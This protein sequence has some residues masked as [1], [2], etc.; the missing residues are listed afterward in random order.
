MGVELG[1]NVATLCRVRDLQRAIAEFGGRFRQ[2]FGLTLDEG[3][4]LCSLERAGRMTAGELA[5]ALGLLPSKVSKVIASVE[6]RGLVERS[7]GEPDHRQMLVSL[8]GEGRVLIGRVKA[9]PP[10]LPPLLE[11]AVAGCAS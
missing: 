11:R 3:M 5:V 9:V 4:L 8:T 6:A 7:V 1:G 2:A 10:D